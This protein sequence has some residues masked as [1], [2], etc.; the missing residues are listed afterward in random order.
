[1]RLV[2]C[3]F[4][5]AAGYL[6]V[7]GF[8]AVV[9]FITYGILTF[10]L[11]QGGFQTLMSEVVGGGFLIGVIENRDDRHLV[12]PASSW[13]VG[14]PLPAGRGISGSCGASVVPQEDKSS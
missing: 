9:A 11:G 5:W 10:E 2:W 4:G 8:V 14:G 7:L 1:M 3:A 6:L 12:G 13:G